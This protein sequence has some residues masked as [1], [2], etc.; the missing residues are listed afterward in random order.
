MCCL[1]EN[2]RFQDSDAKDTG[3][4]SFEY[5]TISGI[6]IVIIH[7]KYRLGGIFQFRRVV[8]NKWLYYTDYIKFVGDKSSVFTENKQEAIEKHEIEKEQEKTSQKTK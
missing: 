1:H 2:M 6:L 3:D 5:L 4:P 8:R 7:E